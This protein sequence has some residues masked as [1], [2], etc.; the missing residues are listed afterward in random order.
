M[1]CKKII[2]KMVFHKR[3]PRLLIKVK[4]EEILILIMKWTN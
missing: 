1:I 3:F 2:F 4:K